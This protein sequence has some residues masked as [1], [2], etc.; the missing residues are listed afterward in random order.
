MTS[1]APIR[2]LLVANRG[3]IAMRVFRTARD[4]GIECVAVYSTADAAAPHVGDADIAVH[5]PGASS[6][7]TY[8][9]GAAVIAAAR[10]AGA[11]A[12]HPGYGFLSENADFA[13]AVIAAGLTWIGPSPDCIRAMALKVQ[14]K[15][16]AAAAGVPLAPGAE[17]PADADDAALLR[18]GEDVGYPLLV[19]ASA[20][21]GGR[22]MRIVAEPSLLL[23][24]VASARREAVSA[25]G[26][27]TV[28]AE[29]Y[30]AGARHVEVQ[31]FGDQRGGVVHLFEREC[32]IQRR[33][34]KVIEEAP[35]PGITEATRGQLLASATALARSI[36]YVGAG[37]VEFLVFGSGADE[38]ACFLEMNTRLQVEHP[39]TEAITG[40]DLVAWQIAVAQGEPLPMGQDQ[41]QA[42]GAAV[43]A[44][45]YAEDPSD[46]FAPAPGRLERF[47]LPE[48]AI[49]G[50]R[51][52][53]G[54]ADGS[55]I[56]THYDP[57]LAKVIAHGPTRQVA[58][59]RL[60]MA[61]R[62]MR[63]HG[64]TSNRDSL[65]AILQHPVFA[66]GV[67]TTDFLAR[68]AEVLDPVPDSDAIQR[69]LLA[70]CMAQATVLREMSL[71]RAVVLR[72]ASGQQPPSI[73][74]GWRN[75]PAARQVQCWRRR[76]EVKVHT[77]RYARNAA[78]LQADVLI[79]GQPPG[80]DVFT[81]TGVDLVDPVV[82]VLDQRLEGD[83]WT[84]SVDIAIAGVSARHVVEWSTGPQPGRHGVVQAFVDDGLVGTTWSEVPLLAR[85]AMHE[86]DRHATTPVPGTITVVQVSDGDIVEPG[87]TLVVLESMKMEHRITAPET[88]R[89]LR[90]R[91][92]VGDAVEAHAVVVEL[93]PVD[94]GDA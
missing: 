68:F 94:D 86:A 48:P 15:A 11:D 78:G 25:F 54:V 40:I 77:L 47:G 42:R 12:I 50:I 58:V 62:R 82:Q 46:G 24:S 18:I 84:V 23:E 32:S 33:H 17:L 36:G 56:T 8:L 4:L 5:L 91:A 90:V 9:D 85:D 30:L 87:Q 29:R 34:Q 72:E 61:L 74:L 14:A 43:E 92:Q 28:F 76:G 65:V 64:P 71:A 31:V 75:V 60:S 51:I 52:D 41:I 63:L 10:R 67:A 49:A 73:P 66:S 53:A 69:H 1:T 16:I 59:A 81:A 2:R 70:V 88:S 55:L 93:A 44:R 80:A 39:V 26:D 22:G 6:A 37:T 83:R 38:G 20:G 13:A 89:V 19:K 7:Q 79:T 57:M 21:G 3:E 35:S 27:G 45:L